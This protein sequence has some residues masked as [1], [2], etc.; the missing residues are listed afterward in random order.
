MRLKAYEF[1][2]LLPHSLI[3]PPTYGLTALQ[4]YK[5]ITASPYKTYHLT[6]SQ[7]Y[8]HSSSESF[9]CLVFGWSFNIVSALFFHQSPTLPQKIDSRE[10]LFWCKKGVVV[11][12]GKMNTYCI[13]PQFAP[14]LGP[15]FA[16]FAAFCRKTQCNMV[17]NA[18]QFGAK[19]SAIW[20]KT[21]CVLMLNAR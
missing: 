2:N 19:R 18:V 9:F 14:A 8:K 3:T 7:A 21:Q 17:Q 12:A 16:K 10:G 1:I 13:K 6:N 5:L 15:L 11:N 4:P 20:C